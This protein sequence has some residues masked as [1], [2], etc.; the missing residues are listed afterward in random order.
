[1]GKKKKK[2]ATTVQRPSKIYER[3]PKYLRF[4]CNPV[5]PYVLEPYLEVHAVPSE[6]FS[7]VYFCY[8]HTTVPVKYRKR[9][10]SLRRATAV[11]PSGVSNRSPQ[12]ARK[13]NV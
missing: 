1:M 8:T 5:E 4:V 7:A 9:S 6:L 10:E 2:L 11:P 12:Y 13:T 3:P